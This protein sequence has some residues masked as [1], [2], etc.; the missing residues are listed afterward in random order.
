MKKFIHFSF[1]VLTTLALCTGCSDPEQLDTKLEVTVTFDSQG[2]SAVAPITV[3][4][5]MKITRPADPTK[6]GFTFENWYS[7]TALTTVYAFSTPVIV[8]LTLYAKWTAVAVGTERE[9]LR[10]LLEQTRTIKPAEYTPESYEVLAAAQAAAEAVLKNTSATTAEILAAHTALEEAFAG[11]VSVY[12][13]VIVG[14]F[15]QC[16][17]LIDGVI[18]VTSNQWI[19]VQAY[20]VNAAGEPVMDEYNGVTFTYDAAQLAKWGEA[21][22]TPTDLRL[23]TKEGALEAGMSELIISSISA[24]AI[25]ETVMFQIA[26]DG[27]LKQIF[28]DLVT[29]LPEPSAVSYGDL[30][31]IQQA[32]NTYLLL[33]EKEQADPVVAEAYKKAQACYAASAELPNRLKFSAFTGDICTL[34]NIDSNRGESVVGTF[35]YTA[36][37]AFPA[38]LFMQNDVMVYN[39]DFLQY[40]YTI[41]ADG[42]GKIE[43]RT[44]D[45]ATGAGATPWE[46]EQQVA[47][48]TYEGSQAEGG[49]I[50]FKSVW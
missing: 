44:V 14:L 6:A 40:Q 16:P 29:A 26:A 32:N 19:S 41:G 33:S 43:Y 12:D 37:G 25:S 46:M 1:L 2:G 42:T 18:Y 21:S 39:G 13:N 27:E 7:D 24:P 20:A 5:G 23:I 47:E 38:G 34:S 10:E 35:T 3:E 31:A 48:V 28:L 45:D 49:I 4:Q 9:D 8:N 22:A 30:S 36:D 15:I 50:Y 17:S 11:L